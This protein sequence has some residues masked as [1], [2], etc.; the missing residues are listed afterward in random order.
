MNVIF[1]VLLFAF[2]PSAKADFYALIIGIDAYKN[3]PTL[4]GAVNDATILR[5]TL[6]NI[7]AKKVKL[8]LNEQV[9]RKDIKQAWDEIIHEAQKGDTIFFTYAGHGA[10]QAERVPHSEE[11]GK[12][13]FY[14]LTN[15][16]ASGANTAERILDDDLQEWFNQVP[17]LTIVL[18]SDSCHSGTM[19][20]G[21]K[22]SNLKYRKIPFQTIT[23]DAIPITR[24]INIVDE[25]QTKLKNVIS[26]SAVSDTEE[27]PEVNIGNQQHGALSW[28]L[29]Q[30]L[31][32]F[33][34]KNKDGSI[35]LAEIK[36]YLLER[37]RMETEGQQHPQIN[38]NSNKPLVTLRA[39]VFNSKNKS[40]SLDTLPFA[41]TDQAKASETLT[42][43]KGV[44]LVTDQTALLTWD[45]AEKVVRNP[46]SDV[47]FDMNANTT[48]A[49][50]R[51]DVG[52]ASSN[53]TEINGEAS[54]N[55][56]QPVI[57]KYLF[58]ERVKRLSDAS[59]K[60]QL[61]PDDKLHAKD[62][63]ITFSAENLRYPYF[64][65]FNLATDGTVNF[66]YPDPSL[67]DPLKIDPKRPYQLNL[68]VSAPFGADHFIVFAS[69]EPF[70]NMHE[71]LNQMQNK[72]INLEQLTQALKTSTN[73]DH[74]QVS[75]LA[76]FTTE[77]K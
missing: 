7:G 2:V 50:K 13:E 61:K 23:D 29:A 41:V 37:V 52:Q 46:F 72:P 40:A 15:F 16:Q 56:L 64:T 11:D 32:G 5:D 12:D 27:V 22:K 58:I 69:G 18:V 45:V 14:A 38:F 33:A 68:T 42:R 24:N 21:Y 73:D 57:N 66:L 53:D 67:H 60:I 28:H 34:D 25:R 3:V 8:L 70:T 74:Y 59:L 44:Q 30:G 26:F 9:T 55:F 54:A 51:S 36:D 76:S 62:E 6:I 39:L 49:Y 19:T 75:V 63:K 10:Q 48:R 65:L 1:L 47:V 17:D 71:V 77:H 35:D 43:L 4:E 20:R 31:L